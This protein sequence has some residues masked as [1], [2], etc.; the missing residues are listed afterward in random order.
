QI[1]VVHVDAIRRAGTGSTSSDFNDPSTGSP[2]AT[3]I[4]GDVSGQAIAAAFDGK[5]ELIVQ[6][7]EPAAIHI[8]TEDRRRTWKTIPLPGPSRTDTGHV[9]FHSNAGGFL[10]CASCHAEGADDGHTWTFQ[11][12]GPRRTPSL[13]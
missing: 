3:A 13:L 5:D 7:R 12:M 9:I 10:A 2:C 11:D 1:Y 8:M 4:Q 6:T